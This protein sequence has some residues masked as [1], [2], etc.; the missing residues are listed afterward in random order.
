M[1]VAG[2]DPDELELVAAAEPEDVGRELLLSEPDVDGE[3]E[4]L[5]PLL[6]ARPATPIATFAA[7]ALTSA[8]TVTPAITI[9]AFLSVRIRPGTTVRVLRYQHSC[10]KIAERNK[11][12]KSKAGDLQ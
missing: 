4:L 6:I 11:A 10:R 3:P 12:Q 7:I 8:I 1:L 2:F 9:A 5:G